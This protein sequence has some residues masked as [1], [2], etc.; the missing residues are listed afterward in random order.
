[1]D[2]VLSDTT[3]TMTKAKLILLEARSRLDASGCERKA[4]EWR[5]IQKIAVHHVAMAMEIVKSRTE[6]CSCQHAKM[7]NFA[8]RQCFC[9]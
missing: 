8:W 5:M 7:R 1:M 2:K 3:Q 4:R 9:L 6:Y